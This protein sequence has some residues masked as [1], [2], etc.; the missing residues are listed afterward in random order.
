MSSNLVVSVFLCCP[1]SVVQP[2]QQGVLAKFLFDFQGGFLQ[3][4]F[5]GGS[6]VLLLLLF[7]IRLIVRKEVEQ[8]GGVLL[9]PLGLGL[10]DDV[11]DGDVEPTDQ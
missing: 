5:L 9:L 1:L 10:R 11:V 4:S 3:A 6:L 8:Y 7:S 2:T